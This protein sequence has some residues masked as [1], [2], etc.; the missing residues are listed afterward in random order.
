M[1]MENMTAEQ[2]RAH[3]RHLRKMIVKSSAT[4]TDADAFGA[5]ELFD[6]WKPDTDYK[7]GNRRRY[8]DEV[9]KL[10][11]CRQNHTS[12]AIYP[13]PIVPALWEEIPEPGQG[14][15]PDNPIPYN[16]NMELLEGKYYRQSDVVY[17]CF[18]STG[19]PVYNNLADLVGIYVNVYTD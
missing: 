19:V 6:K 1:V 4:L 3:F 5:Q 10:Y 16:N 17:I 15:T 8:G 11:K 2:L 9:I 12:Q 14:D 13:P 18:R 7:E